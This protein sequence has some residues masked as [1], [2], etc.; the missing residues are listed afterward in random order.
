MSTIVELD[1]ADTSVGYGGLPDAHG[2]VTLD[3][4]CMHGPQRRAG[5][6]AFLQ[7]VRTPSNVARA[8]ADVLAKD[9]AYAGVALYGGR[10]F[11]VCDEAGPRH[12]PLEGL[13]G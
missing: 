1:P 9:G 12:E 10:N 7:G 11:A 4:C 5:G 6:V 3:A 8:V 13:L 2:N